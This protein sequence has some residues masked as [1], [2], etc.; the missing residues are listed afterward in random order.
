MARFWE[1]T[2]ADGRQDADRPAPGSDRDAAALAALLSAVADGDERSLAALYDAAGAKLFGIALRITRERSLAED[3]LQEAFVHV[4][5]NADRYERGRG[6]PMA[7]L[8]VIVRN[9]S[10]DL[11]RRRG[12]GVQ[13]R[14]VGDDALE[15]MA[16]PVAATDGG[17]EV[18]ALARCLE[19]ME[20]R[21]QELVLLAYFEGW[22]REELAQ[23]FEA[24]VNTIKTWLRRGL[25][26]LRA[27]LEE[28][29]DGS[30]RR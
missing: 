2:I 23:R 1:A 25:L 5:Q 12:R 27:C 22:T 28:E 4:W 10:I 3:A 21:G 16:D 13:G 8:T 18:L 6:S 14:S 30:R 29:A 24:P 11:L 7:W 9:R 19:R 17:V 15:A 26:G 20:E